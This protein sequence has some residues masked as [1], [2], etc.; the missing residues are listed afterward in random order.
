MRAELNRRGLGAA[1]VAD[2]KRASF[3]RD[4]AKTVPYSLSEQSAHPVHI[5]RPPTGVIA[6]ARI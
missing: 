2:G 6:C 4:R 5:C 3:W 1:M